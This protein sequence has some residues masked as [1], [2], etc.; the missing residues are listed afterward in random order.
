MVEQE[1]VH[2]LS[3]LFVLWGLMLQQLFCPMM[4]GIFAGAAFAVANPIQHAPNCDHIYCCLTELLLEL[5]Q[6]IIHACCETQAVGKLQEELLRP[7]ED[8]KK[9]QPQTHMLQAST[10]IAVL[11]SRMQLQAPTGLLTHA[12]QLQAIPY[13]VGGASG[14]SVLDSSHVAAIA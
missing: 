3:L 10:S 12:R 5:P 9:F 6:L 7:Q 11:D 4:H 14:A 8:H 13:A 2:P 1:H